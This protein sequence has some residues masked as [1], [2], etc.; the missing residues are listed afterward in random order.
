L[1]TGFEGQFSGPVGR[2]ELLRAL[3]EEV[4]LNTAQSQVR[5]LRPV[6]NDD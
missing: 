5:D 1:G 4:I 3:L 2:K 6:F